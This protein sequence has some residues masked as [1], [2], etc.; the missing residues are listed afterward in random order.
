MSAGT[1]WLLVPVG[2]R[3]D[4]GWIAET[5]HA[6]MAERDLAEH[7]PLALDFPRQR[8]EACRDGDVMSVVD[9]LYPARGW[10]DGLPVIPP[11][12]GRVEAMLRYCPVNARQSLGPVDPLGGEAVAEKIAANAVMAGCRA[13][14]FPVV[15]AA[16][17][18]ML[19][20]AFNLRGVQ[21][22]DENVAP[23]L[24]VGGPAAAELG[25]NGG[26]GA[27]GPG[28]R[29]NAAIGRALRLVMHNLGGGWPGAV[30]LA[31]LGQPARYSCCFAEAPSPWPPIRADDGF[32]EN[33]NCITLLRAESVINVTGDL[34]ALAG[35]MASPAS[36]FTLRHGGTVAVIIAPYVARM[37]AEKGLAKDD[38]RAWLHEN[39]RM[40]AAVWRDQWLTRRIIREDDWPDWVR[41]A[42]PDSPIPVVAEP[43]DIIVMVAG[44]DQEIPQ[45]AYLPGWG[46]PPCRITL[47]IEATGDW[48]GS[49]S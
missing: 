15:L 27:L 10:T 17:R 32:A 7:V 22:T 26:F 37:L 34:A 21:T 41:N 18:A 6:R 2:Q 12:V 13:L 42:L 29:A 49:R 28:R 30:S 9:R 23:V 40:P 45:C 48:P 46:F 38:V 4:G 24:V 20:P 25:V 36:I 14:D 5:L 31:G 16:V 33:R 19:M 47:P 8:V 43:D 35:V 11:T 44:G 1:V 3:A 39:G